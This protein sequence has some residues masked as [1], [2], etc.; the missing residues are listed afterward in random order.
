MSRRAI[1]VAGLGA[2]AIAVSGCTGDSD[3]EAEFR[4]AFENEF[5]AAPWYRHITG[6]EVTDESGRPHIE[7]TT[8][9]GPGD[10]APEAGDAGFCGAVSD[11]AFDSGAY[12]ESASVTVIGSD[13]V[14][15]GG[16]G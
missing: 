16:C 14:E 15:R 10:G 12:D 7:L 4:A 2:M 9:L 5:S 1:L 11:F 8:D 13:G 6:M 3:P